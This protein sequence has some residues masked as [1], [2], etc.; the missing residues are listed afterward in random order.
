[1]KNIPSIIVLLLLFCTL[2]NSQSNRLHV[3][4]SYVSVGLTGDD[5]ITQQFELGYQ[6]HLSKGLYLTGS[7]MS[8]NGSRSMESILSQEPFYTDDQI[9]DKIVIA[10]EDLTSIQ[11]KIY[12]S[13]TYA[14]GLKKNI[15]LGTKTSMVGGIAAAFNKIK[16]TDL[17]GYNIDET[18]SLDLST[19]IVQ[20]GQYNQFGAKMSLET[21]VQIKKTLGLNLKAEYL[22]HSSTFHLG[23]G[24]TFFISNND[25]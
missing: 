3:I 1:M 20:Y 4:N 14:I 25:Q 19:L 6:R 15:Q 7:F 13:K 16:E 5:V 9:N 8:T 22:T 10:E 17:T 2:A 23:V 21:M 18:G 11:G 24:A 12:H